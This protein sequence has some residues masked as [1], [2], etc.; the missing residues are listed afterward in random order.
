MPVALDY[1]DGECL[2]PLWVS[3]PSSLPT[4]LINLFTTSLCSLS[5]QPNLA[6]RRSSCVPKDSTGTIPYTRKPWPSSFLRSAISFRQD[7]CVHPPSSIKL[8][9]VGFIDKKIRRRGIA[10]GVT[11]AIVIQHR[12]NVSPCLDPS[13]FVDCLTLSTS[14]FS[15]PP[16]R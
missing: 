2:F 13:P 3:S 8:V 15:T 11:I 5:H 4:N 6:K 7:I 16:P 10:L 14:S 12:P 9:L 1:L